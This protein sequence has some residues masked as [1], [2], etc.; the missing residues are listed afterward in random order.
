[1]SMIGEYARLTPAEVDRAVLDPD[2]AREFVDELIEAGAAD[3]GAD[4]RCLDIDK[5]WV[6][7]R[8]NAHAAQ[9]SSSAAGTAGG[10]VCAHS[11]QSASAW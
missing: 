3:A 6:I 1:M 4:A 8:L 9:G 10:T 5:A 2:W 11:A 7:P